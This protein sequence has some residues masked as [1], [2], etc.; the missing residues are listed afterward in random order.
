M[1]DL[2]LMMGAPGS[3]KT[4]FLKNLNYKPP[5]IIISRDE[6]RFSLLKEEEDYFS[7][8][9]EVFKIL[10]ERINKD[11]SKGLNVF[12]DQTSLTP[13]SR[14]WLL[15]HVIGYEHANLVWINEDLNTCLKRNEL[16]AGTRSYVPKSRLKRMW[17]QQ[18]TPTLDEG[19]YRIF[20][21]NGK[22]NKWYYLGR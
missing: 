9:K 22:E 5:Y 2:Y 14:K 7:H 21:Y 8:E 20:I 15:K 12:I 16:R 13:R 1:A 4:T 18:V 11:L 3:G 6:I 10:W 17:Y 19:W